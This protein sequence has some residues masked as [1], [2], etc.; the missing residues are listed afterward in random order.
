MIVLHQ[1]H[2]TSELVNRDD[3]DQD[4]LPLHYGEC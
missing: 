2:R 4:M 1:R 3:H